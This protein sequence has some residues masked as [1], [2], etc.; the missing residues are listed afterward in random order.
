MIEIIDFQRKQDRLEYAKSLILSGCDVN[1]VRNS[2]NLNDED[3]EN[4]QELIEDDKMTERF[5]IA[6]ENAIAEKKLKGLPIARYD[7][8]CKKAYLE[9]P[10]G[11]R[12]YV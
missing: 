8:E 7:R 2:L 6:V 9:F 5:R 3:M 11:R 10:D 12:E 4:V 1:Y